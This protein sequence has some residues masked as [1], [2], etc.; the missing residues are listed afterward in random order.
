M[1]RNK[2][3]LLSLTVVITISLLL[4]GA[5]LVVLGIFDEILN[6]DIFS[7]KVEAVLSGIFFS[8]VALSI[9]GVAMTIVLGIQEIVKAISSLHSDREFNDSF[10]TKEAH[11]TTYM[12]YMSGI[13]AS[14]IALIGIL[15]LV[16]NRIQI[17]RS[18]VFKRIA[19]EQTRKLKTKFVRQITQLNSPPRNKV[20]TTLRD[21]I[22]NVNELSFVESMTLYLPDSED[23]SVIWR[24]KSWDV[25]NKKRGF[26]R[27]FVAKEQ[28]QAIQEAFQG[29]PTLLRAINDRTGFKWY[30]V[31]KN[32]QNQ[33]IAVLRING[34]KRE[35]FREY[36]LSN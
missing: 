29:K 16:N 35:N 2:I 18:K 15:S 8:S 11:K 7:P 9:F 5:T 34:N 28:E 1:R 30:Y 19:A 25:E 24:Y 32:N 33:T 3:K 20:P 10:V 23:R 27:L 14:F 17:H 22:R 12:L 13:M 21:L 36:K 4:L 6:W 26:Q 31:I